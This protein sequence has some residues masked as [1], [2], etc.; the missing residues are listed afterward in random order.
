MRSS[1][2]IRASAAG[3][4]ALVPCGERGR[5]SACSA[6]SMRAQSMFFHAP[7]SCLPA[8]TM[9]ATAPPPTTPATVAALGPDPILKSTPVSVAAPM[10]LRM[11]SSPR[12][13]PAS[14]SSPEN[15]MPSTPAELPSIGP[16]RLVALSTELIRSRLICPAESRTPSYSPY[17]PPQTRPARYIRPALYVRRSPHER[18]KLGSFGF[19]SPGTSRNSPPD[20]AWSKRPSIGANTRGSIAR[21]PCCGCRFA[22]GSI[23]SDMG[24]QGVA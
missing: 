13:A 21:P 11:S 20:M 23:P 22:S 6:Q 14:V 24:L 18:R 5:R 9:A 3:S 12:T 2:S 7:P 8:N 15:I 1:R 19:P 4:C 10:G 16:C 17:E